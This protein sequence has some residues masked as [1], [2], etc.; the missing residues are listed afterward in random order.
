MTL[1]FENEVTRKIVDFVTEI[2]IEVT[3]EQVNHETFLPGILV[4]RGKILVDEAKLKYP[5]DLLHEAGHIAVCPA[6]LRS[7][8]SGEVILP[9]VNM[10]VIESQAI[11]WS[12]AACLHLGLDPRVVFHEAG[13]KGRAEGLLF[14]FS[15]GVYLA[16][17]ELQAA[18]M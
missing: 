4:R 8:L 7:S 2:G 11:A 16:V 10:D 3:H 9:N 5:G 15:V 1:G 13:Y 18:G 17:N 14:N 6:R 12:Y